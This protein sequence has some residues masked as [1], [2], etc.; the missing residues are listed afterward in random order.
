MAPT[1]GRLSS[2]S[3]AVWMVRDEG[4]MNWVIEEIRALRARCEEQVE[5]LRKQLAELEIELL[6]LAAAERVAARTLAEHVEPVEPAAEPGGQRG[7][8]ARRGGP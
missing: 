7:D 8:R 5:R 2:I 4:G 1:P 3:D 6:D